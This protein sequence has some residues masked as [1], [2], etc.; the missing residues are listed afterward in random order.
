MNTFLTGRM[1]R[2]GGAFSSLVDFG[3]CGIIVEGRSFILDLNFGVRLRWVVVLR[4]RTC[5]KTLV[6][7]SDVAFAFWPLQFSSVEDYNRT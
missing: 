4:Y 7:G 3:G 6:G 5:I 2:E 1:Q